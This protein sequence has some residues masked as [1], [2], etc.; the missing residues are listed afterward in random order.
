MMGMGAAAGACF[1]AAQV[2]TA[3]AVP[4]PAQ[5][6]EWLE[7]R[8]GDNRTISFEHQWTGEKLSVPYYERGHVLIDALAEVDHI[9]RDHRNGKIHATDPALLDTL[10]MM[11]RRLGTDAPIQV[12]CGYRSPET[13]A[14]LAEQNEGVAKHSF[15]M[16]GM[17]IDIRLPNRD[18]SA[19]RA[20]ALDLQ[21][22]GV[23]YY[24]R[25][26]FLH[27]DSGPVRSWS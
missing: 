4:L 21:R 18:V 8:L 11:R 9:L 22:G 1:S 26:N 12:V 15:H 17:A 10:V 19:M 16:E 3:Y 13:N 25:S 27:V 7:P 14:M 2:G 24:P 5:K 23:G 6:P 20:V